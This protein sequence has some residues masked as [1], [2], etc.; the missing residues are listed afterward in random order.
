WRLKYVFSS[1]AGVTQRQVKFSGKDCHLFLHSWP[2]QLQ[3]SR[4][5]LLSARVRYPN[6]SEQLFRRCA[7]RKAKDTLFRVSCQ[8]EMSHAIA[9]MKPAKLVQDSTALRV[10]PHR[11]ECR[12]NGDNKPPRV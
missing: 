6:T 2:I 1:A 7:F 12:P 10:V 3:T 11:S 4:V 9:T 8:L 5:H